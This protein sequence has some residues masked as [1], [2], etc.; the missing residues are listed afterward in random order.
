MGQRQLAAIQG[1]E[2]KSLPWSLLSN[3]FRVEAGWVIVCQAFGKL[4]D[5]RGLAYAR[6]S[7][8][9]D[10][11]HFIY[12]PREPLDTFLK[13]Q[14]QRCAVLVLFTLPTL[15]QEISLPGGFWNAI[16]L[17]ADQRE[18]HCLLKV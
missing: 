7:G 3:F 8:E 16:S 17:P 18:L 15:S 4:T 2:P 10:M 1:H 6:Q 5:Q 14:S 9:K 11:A 13:I 12:R